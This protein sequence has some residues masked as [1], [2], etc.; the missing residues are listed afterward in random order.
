M[1]LSSNYEKPCYKFFDQIMASAS[2][3]SYI[4]P[5]QK[6]FICQT[7]FAVSG[8]WIVCPSQATGNFA[9]GHMR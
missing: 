1:H 7:L 9:S 8:F 3:V 2:F 4:G 6:V 5:L